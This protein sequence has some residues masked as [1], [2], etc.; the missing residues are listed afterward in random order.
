MRGNRLSVLLGSLG[1]IAFLLALVLEGPAVYTSPPIA[2]WGTVE[3]AR[4]RLF[5]FFEETFGIPGSGQLS[6]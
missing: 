1:C 4:Y 2:A 5:S 6:F 3:I